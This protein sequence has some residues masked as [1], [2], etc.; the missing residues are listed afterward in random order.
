MNDKDLYSQ[1]LGIKSPFSVESVDLNLEAQKVEVLLGR[2]SNVMLPCPECGKYCPIHDHRE[3]SWRHLDTCQLQT[4]LRAF[5]PR[6]KCEKH[7]VHQIKVPWGEPG[8]SFT[9]LFEKL[10]IDWLQVTTVSSVSKMLRVTWDQVY[11]IQDRAVK[12][13]LARREKKPT[14]HIGIDETSFQKRHEYVTV[15]QDKERGVVLEVLDGRK[16]KDVQ[17]H[18]ETWT[19]E[20]KDHVLAVSMDM[21]PAYI[22]AISETFSEAN[23]IICFDRFHVSQHFCNAVNKVR[24]REHRELSSRGDHRLAK[25]KFEFL[26]TAS[27]LDNRSRQAFIKLTKASLKTARVWAVKEAAAKLWNYKS[28]GWA[29]KGWLALILWIKRFRQ[30]EIKKVGAMVEKHL[31]GILNAICHGVSNAKMESINTKIQKMKNEACGYRN[32]ERFRNAILF[33]FGG[34]DLAPEVLPT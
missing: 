10:I 17:E 31:W 3:R 27:N 14:A 4:I 11:G 12:R 32:R 20:E 2:I 21:W 15:I 19:R 7:G 6:V 34:L 26:K 9:A 5:V 16:Q 23:G 1:I 8:S 33:R 22:N 29:K 25:T 13:G 28:M 30:P 24:H 18:F